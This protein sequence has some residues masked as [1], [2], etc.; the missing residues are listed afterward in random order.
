MS[1]KKYKHQFYDKTSLD[2]LVSHPDNVSLW[3]TKEWQQMVIN[4]G[5]ATSDS[6]ILVSE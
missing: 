5:D 4:A 3:Q 6:A 1:I 2:M